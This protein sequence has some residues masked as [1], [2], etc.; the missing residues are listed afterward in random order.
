MWRPM[1]KDGKSLDLTRV[2][3]GK[4]PERHL[5]KAVFERLKKGHCLKRLRRNSYKVLGEMKETPLKEAFKKKEES[6]DMTNQA[7]KRPPLLRIPVRGLPPRW[8]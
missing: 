2:R 8:C 5:H 6:K 4:Y 3:K 1:N 7:N